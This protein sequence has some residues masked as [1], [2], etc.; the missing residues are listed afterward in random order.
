MKIILALMAV[1]AAGA[2]SVSC[3]SDSPSTTS[4]STSTASPTTQVA[5]NT[6]FPRGV[7]T[8]SFQ[9]TSAGPIS[10]TLTTV[11]PS[12][13]TVLGLGL[14]IPNP[15]AAGCV[16]FTTLNTTAGSTPQITANADPG[17]YCMAVY[18]VGFVPPTGVS[19]SITIRHS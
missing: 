3:S 7:S 12:P 10:V 8:Q 15:A 5:A 16:F 2:L 11:G 17:S 19:Y 14:G 1:L 4:P 13:S 9:T 18:D 6:L